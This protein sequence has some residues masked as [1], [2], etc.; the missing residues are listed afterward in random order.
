MTGPLPVER[1][2]A[3]IASAT[4]LALSAVT[5]LISFLIYVQRLPSYPVQSTLILSVITIVLVAVA[6]WLGHAIWKAGTQWPATV[7]LVW[8]L[9]KQVIPDLI[10]PNALPRFLYTLAT[11]A[12]IMV[13]VG[14]RAAKSANLTPVR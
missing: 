7:L 8:A 14:P 1:R 6:T 13:L 4:I 3:G 11:V 2:K 10:Y 9:I 5:S 12:A